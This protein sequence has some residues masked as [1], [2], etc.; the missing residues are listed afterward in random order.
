MPDAHRLLGRQSPISFTRLGKMA[1]LSSGDPWKAL[2]APVDFDIVVGWKAILKAIFP[3]ASDRDL[4]KLVHLSNSFRLLPGQEPLRKDDMVETKAQINAVLNQDSGNMVEVYGRILRDGW[5]IMEATRQFLYR[6]SYIGCENTFQRKIETPI[7]VHMASRRD[8]AVLPSKEWFHLDDPDT[9]LLGKTLTFRL[10][11]FIRFKDEKNPSSVQTL[12]QA[13]DELPAK[14]VI[15]A[16]SVQYITG[17]SHGNPVTDYL[18]R[19][20]TS[21][22]QPVKFDNAIPLNSKTEFLIRALASNEGYGHASSDC[23]PIHVSRTLPS[24]G[25][26]AGTIPSLM[27]CSHLRR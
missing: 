16:A 6:G 11:S 22:A 21:L 18:Q 19:H 25:I 26:L 2:Y 4:L 23:N 27:E 15:Q 7:Q 12:G 24:Y 1:R 9:K 8:A 17:Q 13:L 10:S 5:P 20:G 3:N 14:E